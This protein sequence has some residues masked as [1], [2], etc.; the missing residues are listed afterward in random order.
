MSNQPMY[1]LSI[2]ATCKPQLGDQTRHAVHVLQPGNLSVASIGPSFFTGCLF[3]DTLNRGLVIDR[4]LQP[5]SLRLQDIT[6]VET[7]G[8]GVVM[9]QVRHVC[10]LVNQRAKQEHP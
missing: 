7:V 10:K 9:Q 4:V 3:L 5:N 8:H 6:T 1:V 2:I